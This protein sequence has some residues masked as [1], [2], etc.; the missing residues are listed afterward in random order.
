MSPAERGLRS[1]HF[2][3]NVL[4]LSL[5]HVAVPKLDTVARGMEYVDGSDQGHKTS[6]VN[7][8]RNGP[9]GPCK[10]GEGDVSRIREE[11]RWAATKCECRQWFFSV[12]YGEAG[13]ES[14]A[15]TRAA[16]LE[17][18]GVC[19]ACLLLPTRL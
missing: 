14:G 2:Q 8:R 15:S 12:F 3:K 18:S 10:E 6:P 9:V 4:K 5:V 17:E 1:Q 16:C 7:F 11:V 13:S 19:V